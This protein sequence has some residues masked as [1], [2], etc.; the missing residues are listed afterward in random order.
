MY[1]T[2]F[3]QYTATGLAQTDKLTQHQLVG[4]SEFFTKSNVFQE[5]HA[6]C[7]IT[8]A[9]KE[10]LNLLKR[11]FPLAVLAYHFQKFFVEYFHVPSR[12]LDKAVGG[13]LGKEAVDAFPARIH[14]IPDIRL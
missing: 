7:R 6:V 3:E 4:A 2:N 8:V 13:E 9:A 11:R 14:P 1:G 5:R 12:H 10:G